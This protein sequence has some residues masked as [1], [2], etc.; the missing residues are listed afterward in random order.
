MNLFIVCCISSNCFCTF[1][2]CLQ[3]KTEQL[4]CHWW[5]QTISMGATSMQ[6]FGWGEPISCF[7]VSHANFFVGGG[8]K[9]IAKLDAGP[10]LDFPRSAT[11][12]CITSSIP[13]QAQTGLF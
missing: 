6:T 8:P 4:Y 5:I 7:P 9:S 2:S 3:N 12:Y 11:V 10:W 13:P 1:P